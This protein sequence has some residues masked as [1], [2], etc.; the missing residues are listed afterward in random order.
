MTNYSG[1]SN[2]GALLQAFAL[3]NAI[4]ELG[5]DVKTLYVKGRGRSK[6][7][8]YKKLVKSGRFIKLLCQIKKDFPEIRIRRLMLRRRAA[9]KDFRT[10]IPHTRLYFN[11]DFKGL[12]E[13]YD[14]FI[15]GSDQ[16]FRPDEEK[17]QLID[18]YWLSM[19]DSRKCVKAS[20]AASMGRE[21]LDDA[22]KTAAR[23]YLQDFD[24][25]SLR[26]ETAMKY[27]QKLTGRND[28][29]THC[30]PVFLISADKWHAMEKSYR[31]DGKYLL[32]YMIHGSETLIKSIGKFAEREHLKI[33][34]FPYMGYIYRPWESR[35]GDVRVFDASPEQFLYIL[36]HAE[37]VFTDSFHGTAF[38]IIYHKKMFVSCANYAA[39]SRISNILT[40][41]QLNGVDI[42]AEGIIDGKYFLKQEIDWNLAD[43]LI[44]RQKQQATDY[45]KTVIGFNIENR[46][47]QKG[48]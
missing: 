8:K 35:A 38:S 16:I 36:D 27:F 11:D 22:L 43:E 4:E 24:F 13:E 33:V 42:P 41:Y 25:I 19:V 7:N 15:A 32:V 14:V 6:I 23:E 44:E 45:L 2:Y 5:Y 1:T 47:H 48:E 10:G 34:I 20:Y 3:N 29:A 46:K 28:V 39:F 18:Y 31:I 21:K 40:I 9:V 17:E 12:N 37:Y 30:D 26:E